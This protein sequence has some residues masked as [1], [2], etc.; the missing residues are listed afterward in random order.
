MQLNPESSREFKTVL[1]PE[2]EQPL[3]IRLRNP[4]T[5][6]QVVAERELLTNLPK[7]LGDIHATSGLSC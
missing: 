6:C 5:H 3:M 7:P 4:S 1:L 2:P